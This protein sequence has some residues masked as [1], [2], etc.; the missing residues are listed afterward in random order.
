MNNSL[1]NILAVDPGSTTIGVSIFTLDV[2]T[3][4]I[5]NIETTLIDTRIGFL[6]DDVNRDL[7][8]RLL[9]LRKRISD[10]SIEYCPSI[11]AMEDSFMNRFRPAAVT[12]LSQSIFAV[13]VGVLDIFPDIKI[14]KFPPKRI[15]KFVST[16]T[17]TKD[18]M[19]T[20]VCS[21]SCI[22][23]LIDPNLVSEHEV[24]SLAVGYT[25]IET[26]RKNK[27]ILHMLYN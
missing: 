13:E 19:L 10:I 26:L 7:L 14:F 11:L 8:N 18:D 23:D 1:I 17:A 6:E 12:P 16:G 3:F 20:S 4:N 5:V 24:D 15:K 25:M 22:S 27:V 9:K 21:L 2:I